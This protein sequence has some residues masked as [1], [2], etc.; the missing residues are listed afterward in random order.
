MCNLL[1]QCKIFVLRRGLGN[2]PA[3]K[4]HLTKTR[5]II[6]Y[7]HKPIR[8]KKKHK[9][10]KRPQQKRPEKQPPDKRHTEKKPPGI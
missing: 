3:D 1:Q 5:G 4:S 9:V 10:N 8:K 7:R 6:P 2:K